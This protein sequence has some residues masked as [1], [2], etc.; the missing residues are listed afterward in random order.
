MKLIREYPGEAQKHMPQSC[1]RDSI[2][3]D[4]MQERLKDGFIA[5]ANCCAQA[6]LA[7]RNDHGSRVIPFPSG[8]APP[9]LAHSTCMSLRRR[10]SANSM[11]ANL[12]RKKHWMSRVAS[13]YP[14][15]AR[16]ASVACEAR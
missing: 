16:S 8:I 2:Q 13:R 15:T 11:T 5:R 14:W 9:T 3:R 1:Q 6:E 12:R 4:S 7:K 10:L